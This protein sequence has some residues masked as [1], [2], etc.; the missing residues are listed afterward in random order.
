MI[1]LQDSELARDQRKL[2]QIRQKK[3]QLAASYFSEHAEE[4]DSLRVSIVSD[5]DVEARLVEQLQAIP[6]ELFLDLGT[7]TGR[8][9]E[10]IAP[11]TRKGIGFDLSRE[12]LNVARS[13][14]DNARIKNC[15]VRHSD[16]HS[17]KL[18][19]DC[20]DA[21]AIHQ[22]LHYCD[23]PESVVAEAARLLKPGGT[24]IIVDFLPHDLEFLRENHAHQ[25]LGFADTTI[26]QWLDRNSFSDL[27]SEKLEARS[28]ADTDVTL[29]VGMWRATL[30]D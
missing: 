22:V 27:Q 11:F 18:D 21:I 1:D 25:R 9:L 29:T 20:A 14:L 5:T 30:A 12:M 23:N 2:E 10:I 3:S 7:G 17:I 26:R 15:T 24:L 28:G 8:I 4:W 19:D 16:I 13:N 6:M